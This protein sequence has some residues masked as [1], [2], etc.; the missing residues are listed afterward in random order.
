MTA[1]NGEV[2]L[3]LPEASRAAGE[4]YARLYYRAI[5][6]GKLKATQGANGRYLISQS[7]LERYLRERSQPG[8]Q[9]AA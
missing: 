1:T 3:T 5:P 6:Q 7:E 4:S 2:L 8:G 9:R